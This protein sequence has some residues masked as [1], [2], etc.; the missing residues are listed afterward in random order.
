MNSV[1][2]VGGGGREHALHKAMLRTERPLCIYAY[3]GN[4]GMMHDGCMRI[5]EHFSSWHELAD[6]ACENEIDCTVIG[7]EQPLADGIVDIFSEKGLCAFGPA[8]RA[9]R[10]EGDKEWAK[11]FMVRH[12]IPTADYCAFCTKD[13]A[14]EFIE[15][16][17]G[18]VVVKASGLAAGK[19]VFV[20]SCLE[21]ANDAL[22]TIFDKRAF[23]DAGNTV[24]VEDVLTGIEVSILL[25]TDGTRYRLFPFSRDH[26]AAYDGD[27]GPNTGGMGAYA[28][29]KLVDDTCAAQIESLLV[30]PTLEGLRKER[31]DY[32]GILYI[33]AILTEDGPKV[34]EYNCRFGDP[35]TQAVLPLVHTDWFSAF[36]ECA[37][38]D[39]SSVTFDIAPQCCASVVLA[40]QGYP[41]AYEKGKKIRV[42]DGA[43]YHKRNVD[44]YHAGTALDDDGNYL[45]NGGRVVSVSAWAPSL[46]EAIDNAYN[47]ADTVDFDG[48]QMRRDI[49]K[50]ERDL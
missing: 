43:E 18:R 44:I 36:T 50:R 33:G 30:Q 22:D 19:G 29:T 47:A 8:A 14:R 4:P 20:C 49:G 42:L 6:W 46:G 32:R 13:E 24:V 35:E 40:S 15:K 17:Q 28:P 11:R 3:P 1:L 23:G 9:A 25:L 39:I 38:G 2:I 41:G 12:S 31:I 48:K 34:L 7:P 10:I 5:R 21:E 26:K 16:K 27:K 45:T 37:Q